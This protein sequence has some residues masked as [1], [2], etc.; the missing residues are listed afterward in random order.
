M[1]YYYDITY[2]K[3]KDNLVA[4]SLSRTFDDHIS[5]STIS[6]PIPN[7]LQFVQQGDVNEFSLF[8]IT[9]RL[10][11]N[12]YVVPHYSLYGSSLRYKGHLVLPQS[13]NIQQAFF[14]EIHASPSARHSGFLKMYERARRN[15]FWKGMKWEIQ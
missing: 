9:Q 10:E 8:V 2:K 1:V 3:A 7:W 6:M 15:L 13:T 4:D 12:P 11:N 14:Y 5:L